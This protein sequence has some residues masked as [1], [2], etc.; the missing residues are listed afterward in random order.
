MSTTSAPPVTLTTSA[1]C[2]DANG[3]LTGTAVVIDHGNSIQINGG[4]HPKG[5]LIIT[6]NCIESVAFGW[7]VNLQ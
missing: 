2:Y 7:F 1:K 4:E 3:Y 6:A 5:G